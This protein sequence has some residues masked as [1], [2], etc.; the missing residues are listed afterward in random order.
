M[1]V[2]IISVDLFL[3]ICFYYGQGFLPFLTRISTQFEHSND[4]VELLRGQIGID[5]SGLDIGVPQKLLHYIQRN[6]Q[7]FFQNVPKSVMKNIPLQP[8]F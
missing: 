8:V 7:W 2:D 3:S 5:F 1:S 4:V 6:C